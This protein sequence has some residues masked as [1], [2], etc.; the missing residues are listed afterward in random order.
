MRPGGEEDMPDPMNDAGFLPAGDEEVSPGPMNDAGRWPCATLAAAS[1]AP[2][3]GVPIPH[4]KSAD[5]P[6]DGWRRLGLPMFTHSLKPGEGGRGE[7]LIWAVP[8]PDQL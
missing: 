2:L 8:D 3:L 6:A 7:E 5:T 1:M 4:G